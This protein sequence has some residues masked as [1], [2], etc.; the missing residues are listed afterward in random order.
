MRVLIVASYNK[1]CFAPFILEQVQALRQHGVVVDYFGV[2]GKGIKGYLK[3]LSSLRKKIN[4]FHPDIIHAHYGLSGLLANLQRKVPVVTTYH[5]SDINVTAVR[6]FSKIAIRLSAW[7]VFV[8][9]RNVELAKIHKRYSLL[10]CGIDVDNFAIQNKKD[11][12]DALQWNQNGKY[13]LFAGAFD[14]AVKNAPL[15]Q[16]AMQL[17]PEVRLIELKGYSRQEVATLFCAADA[18]LLTSF[19]EG[20]P[21]VVKEAMACN[22]PVV[23]VVVGDVKE[24]LEKVQPSAIVERNP[25]SIA[26]ALHII[27]EQGERSNG[28]E[29]LLR[30]GLDNRKVAEK[31]IQIY[32]NILEKV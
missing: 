1:N 14:N 10:P 27:L 8:S 7:N 2:V 6:R 18:L 11:A 5:G 13:V 16:A 32:N 26:N 17:L 29:E 25:Q 15:A 24:R 19:T 30:Q 20:S 21:Q 4:E 3:A 22:C 28:R 12:R 9:Q 31:L 23:T